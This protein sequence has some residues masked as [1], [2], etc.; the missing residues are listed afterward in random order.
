[1]ND[2]I[3][4]L[5]TVLYAT[6][7]TILECALKIKRNMLSDDCVAYPMEP[8]NREYL[9]SLLP[10]YVRENGPIIKVEEIFAIHSV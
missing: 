10:S 3:C 4:L 6:E 5:I 2:D 9:H 7:E 8:E 1:M